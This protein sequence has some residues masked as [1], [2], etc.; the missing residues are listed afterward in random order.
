MDILTNDQAAT[1]ASIIKACKK[2]Q[3]EKPGIRIREMAKVLNLSE[4]QLLATQMDGEVTRLKPEWEKI[5][6]RLPE[7]GRVMS[8]TRNDSCILEHKGAFEK[9]NVFGKGDHKIGTVIGPIETRV[10]LNSWYVAYAVK[11]RKRDRSLTSLQVFDHEG[12]AIT[13]IY[14]QDDSDFEAYEKLVADFKADDQGTTLSVKAYTPVDYNEAV[15][16]KVFLEDWSN[17]KDTH[18]F[19]P[20]LK[21]YKVHR[22]HAVELAKDKFAY[23]IQIKEVQELVEKAAK[24]KLP[25]M[26]FA[27][28]RGN[29]QIHQDTIR[30][31]R[32]LE[33]GH[34]GI[35]KWLNVLD[36]NFNMHLR[37]DL[38]E[39][40]WV[41]TK[42]TS[43]GDVTSVECFDADKNLV[44][45]FFG[46]RKPGQPELTEWKELVSALHKL[47]S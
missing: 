42:P 40:A 18:D 19:F 6:K 33:R 37:M 11:S 34:T 27:G 47:D 32:L 24:Q 26:I 22:Y 38:V 31:I 30:T 35:E 43:D 41:V 36:P 21:K 3:E 7:L 16:Q 25:I 1:T 9:V 12:N 13:K 45:Q 39:Y 28:N 14:L 29:L 15:D 10:F 4:A 17:L 5:L 23:P 8:L 44:V 20:L 2:V 46:L